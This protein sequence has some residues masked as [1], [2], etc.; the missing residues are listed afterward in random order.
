MIIQRLMFVII[1][2]IKFPNNYMTIKIKNNVDSE[3]F[4][5]ILCLKASA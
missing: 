2:K 3:N 1:I 5:I 4:S